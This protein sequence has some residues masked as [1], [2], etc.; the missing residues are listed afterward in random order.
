[1]SRKEA[2][3]EQKLNNMLEAYLDENVKGHSIHKDVGELEFEVR[4]NRGKRVTQIQY[5]NVIK[6]LLSNKYAIASETNLLR[7]GL[8]YL[9]ERTGHNKQSSIRVELEGLANISNYCK[10]DK[11]NIEEDIGNFIKFTQKNNYK[12]SEKEYIDPIDYNNFGFR[13][14]FQTEKNLDINH[15][16]IKNI[17]SQW[18]NNKKTFRYITRHKMVHDELPFNIDLSIVKESKKRGYKYI[19]EYTFR[20]SGVLDSYEIYEIEIEIDNRR[21]GMGTEYDNVEK[22]N[23]SLKKVIKYILSG[24]QDTSYPISYDEQ[25][26]V[27]QEYNN[28]LWGTKEKSEHRV[29]LVNKNFVGPSSLTLQLQNVSEPDENNSYPN[30]RENYTVTDKADGDRKMLF[31]TKNGHLYLI[32]TNMNIQFT[33]SVTKRNEYYNTLIDGEHILHSKT[34]KYINLFAGFDIYYLNGNDIRGNQ[35]IS[36]E[37]GNKTKPRLTI[38]RDTIKNLNMHSVLK[39]VQCNFRVITK[40]F[41]SSDEKNSIFVGCNSILKKNKEGLFEYYIDGL[42]FT[43]AFLGVG[44]DTD[45]VVGKP[46]KKTWQHCIKWKP[47]KDN[48]ID[49]LVMKKKNTA[50]QDFVGNIFEDGT[51]LSGTS[52]ISQY[53]TLLLHVGFN[54]KIHGYI[55]PCQN[56][57]DDNIELSSLEEDN[58]DYK[59]MQFYPTN[60]NDND[61]GICNLLLKHG[62]NGDKVLLTENNEVIEDNMIVEFRYI[63]TNK[64]FWKWVPLRIRYDK[65]ADL[66]SGS[67]NYGNAY[68]VANSNWH[69]IHNPITEHMIT[70]G[71]DIPDALV[72][73]DVYYNKVSKKTFTQGLR[74]FH[75]LYVK[76][77]LITAVS[78]R[79]GTLIDYSVGKGGD[80]PK[81]IASKLKFVFGI[82]ISRDN[83]ENRLDGACARYL[84]NRKKFER[85][86]RAL[87]VVGNSSVNIRNGD[88]IVS[89]KSKQITK[90]IFGSGAKDIKQLG[91]IAYQHY[92]IGSEGF[93]VGSIQFAIHYMFENQ[94]TLQ[95]FLRNV[96][97]S[98]KIGGYFIGT[99]YD[100][101]TIFNYLKEK[102]RGENII[103]MHETKKIW[104]ITKDYDYEKFIPDNTSVGYAIDVY[105]ETIN[106]HFKEYLVHY[107]YLKRLMENYG[108]A[109]LSEEEC[110]NI[111]LRSSSGLFSSLFAD[112]VDENNRYKN[113]NK[114]YGNA[115]N[116]TDLEKQISFLNRYFIFKKVRNVDAAKVSKA[117][118]NNKIDEIKDDIMLSSKEQNEEEQNEEE[119][120]EEE[121]NEGEQN[122][123]EQNEE[124]QNEE[125]IKKDSV[126]SKNKS[127]SKK[128]LTKFVI[129]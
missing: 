2:N 11:L 100:G 21:V 78:K 1:M 121:Q 98:I 50:G 49:F 75:N 74:N 27:A 17:T 57:I 95:N 113:A 90:A 81:W 39:D 91:K 71:K 72:D 114:S 83:I 47:E 76:K 43:P 7:I 109:E 127:R 104:E 16:L 129:E 87:F 85:M 110:R 4:F 20:E 25:N 123:G 89:D 12:T 14:S 73:D 93:D 31:I 60:P 62:K 94:L 103:K 88:A 68:H 56:V 122:E 5:E 116:M 54:E 70:T 64:Q 26:M 34:G 30:I 37:E 10:T 46:L 118:I 40:A 106:K 126:K 105:Q 107:D 119:Q 8:E 99:C 112:M 124:E 59:P 13:V 24:L 53:K 35:F 108:F 58:D 23:K 28:L 66:R 15:P 52:Q 92:G 77:R 86:F 3:N 128:K 48:T 41:Y 79:G 45:N 44:A 67:K 97:E 32:D 84:N 63:K 65:T 33:G 36:G 55:N 22:V 82:D 111:G 38:L 115:I 9:D 19:S 69:T 102:S 96:S 6:R 117:L 29:K 101:E 42:I 61:A 51:N 125:E 120:N 80:I 18:G